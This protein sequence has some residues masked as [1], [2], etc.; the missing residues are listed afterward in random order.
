MKQ[1][2]KVQKLTKSFQF[3]EHTVTIETG[4]IARQASATVMV[5]MADTVVMVAVV[6]QKEAKPGQSFFPLT[7]NYQEKFYAAGRIPGGFFK[8]EGRPTEKETLTCRLI[9]R[10]IR[11]LFPKGFLNEVQVTANLISSNP[12][13]DG[14]IPALIGTSAALA[15]SGM[16]FSGPIGASK[17]G[18]INNEYVLNPSTTQLEDSSLNLIV[19]GTEN[20][21]LM[22]ESEA[23]LLP[24]DVMLGAVTFGHD[25]M[26]AVVSAINELVAEAGV[27]KWGW[28]AAAE[29]TDLKAKVEAAATDGLKAAYAI[30]DKMERQ[31]AV[32]EVKSSLIESLC[33]EEDENAPAAADVAGALYKLEKFLVRDHI[34]SGNPRIDGRDLTTVRPITVKP[35]ILPRTHGSALFTRG[36]TQAIVT[37]T[38]GTTRDAQLIDAVNGEY[39]DPFMLHYNFPLFCVGETGFAGG[40]KRREIGHGWLARRGVTAVLPTIEDFP[41]VVRV[42][43]EITE[44]NGSS[45]MAS[46]CGTSLALMDAGVPVKAPVAGIAMGLIKEGDRFAVLSDILGDEDHLGDMDF[47]VAGT[48]DGITALQMDIKIEGINEEIMRIA[49]SQAHEGRNFILGE[50]NKVISEPRGEMSEFAPRLVTIKIHPDKIRDVIG[51]GGVTIRSIT[52]ETG[53]TIDIAD[54]G[55]ITIGSVNKEAGDDARKRIEQ[56]TADIEPGQ[57]FEGKVIKIMNFGAFVSLTPGRD[58]LVH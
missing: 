12:E 28:E 16:P 19:A 43:S 41:Y 47:K 9:D 36:E 35:G 17:V 32:A 34:L 11:P 26:K 22:V 46:V 38:L 58:G 5:N 7:V 13:V 56:I 33:N 55:T 37:T 48:A 10:P 24:E 3:G 1:E 23:D 8:R 54:D 39:K 49:L 30:A 40:P 20:A 18:Y 57:I 29:D 15:L 27:E 51:K 21:V 25:A 14:D 52:E 6:G 53:A 45:S 4:E 31:A 2:T 50:M 44:S 42:V